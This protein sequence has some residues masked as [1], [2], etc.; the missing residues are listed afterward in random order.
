MPHLCPVTSRDRS[1]R[2]AGRAD[3]RADQLARCRAGSGSGRRPLG[4]LAPRV[5]RGGA[6]ERPGA[7][8]HRADRGQRYRDPR[9]RRGHVHPVL[10]PYHPLLRH[11]AEE[12]WRDRGAVDGQEVKF[13]HK[14]DTVGF[15]FYGY[16]GVDDRGRGGGVGGM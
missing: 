16:R 11:R 6:V 15:V 9:D 4:V 13:N 14:N 12:G 7:A 10:V 3:E 2:E 5:L 8:P 1:G